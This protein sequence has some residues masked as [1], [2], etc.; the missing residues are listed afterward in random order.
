VSPESTSSTG[1]A[2][3]GGCGVRIWA[4]SATARRP[5]AVTTTPRSV[6]RAVV[7]A[8]RGAAA[9]GRRDAEKVMPKKVQHRPTDTLGEVNGSKRRRVHDRR[10]GFE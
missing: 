10:R 8:R 5:K 2:R 7:V 3:G 9:V 1:V 6:L 4:A